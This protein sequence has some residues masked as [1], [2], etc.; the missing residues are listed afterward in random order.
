MSSFASVDHGAVLA[1][2]DELDAAF[3]KVA[4]LPLDALTTA[5][6]LALADRHERLARR[7]PALSH[8]LINRL[9]TEI[10]VQALGGTS[11][12]DVLMT[13]LRIS[14][15]EA[16]RRITDADLLGPRHTLTGEP[17]EPRLPTTSAAQQRGDIG[18]EHVK[19]IKKF[20]EDLPGYVDYDVR[21]HAEAHLGDL[22]CGLGPAELRQAADRLAYLANQDGPLPTDKDRARRRHLTIGKQ[23]ADGMSKVTALLDP[24]GRAT[25][26]AVLAKSAAPGMGNPDD[27]APCVDG[28]PSPDQAFSDT[29]SQGQ[30]NHDA[31]KAMCRST[32]ASGE[33]GQHNGLPATIIVSTT[34]QELQSG[35]GQA[36]TGGG[37]LLPMADVIRLAAH[38]H[39][40][41]AVFDK[42]TSE[43]LY[44]GRTKRLAS[45]GQ[46]IV[47]HA[48]DRGCTKPGCT[49]PGYW[50]Q[51][52]HAESDWKDGGSTD[53]TD[54]TLACGPDNR[55]VE[56]GG[57]R[58]RKRKD[59]RTEWIPPPHLDTGQ[60]RINK[61]H[62]PQEYL[63]DND[64]DDEGDDNDDEDDAA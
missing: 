56:H 24:E 4:S 39:H 19:V 25:L 45:R 57:W 16:R 58:T 1:A 34:L 2:Y 7:L 10:D 17:L 32:L 37:S 22:A 14:K 8:R 62:H 44:L 36:V 29:R 33:L 23:D 12:A 60:A 9:A 52:H 59:G 35:Q 55:L 11:L 3:D 6:Q 13:R 15:E 38:A 20:F 47:L 50:C 49:A 27:D 18:A 31:L 26:D 43:P 54:V 40:Y 63:T 21:E 48:K 28:K 61:Y 5:E 42:H 46:R 64:D 30:R 51:V 53:I 41:L